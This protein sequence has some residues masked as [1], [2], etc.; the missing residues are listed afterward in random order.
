MHA[1]NAIHDALG[2]TRRGGERPDRPEPE[3]NGD[4]MDSA[5]RNAPHQQFGLE[6]IWNGAK[7]ALR[8]HTILYAMIDEPLRFDQDE[9][10][11]GELVIDYQAA[12][13][14][15]RCTV[16]GRNMHSIAQHI[17]RGRRVT[18]YVQAEI[19]GVTI[20]KIEEEE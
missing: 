16:R 17:M 6:I 10:G 11:N 19:D 20:E 18:L 7:G 8:S 14:R 4:T 9:Q 12:T 5:G 3:S 1:K 2:L 13:G 15:Y